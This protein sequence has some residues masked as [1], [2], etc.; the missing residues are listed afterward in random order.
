MSRC[1]HRG[2]TAWLEGA[3]EVVRTDT[4]QEE[5]DLPNDCVL[6]V[7]P[8]LVVLKLNM[9]AVLNSHLHL[10]GMHLSHVQHQPLDKHH[11]CSSGL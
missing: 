9:Q 3:A 6:Q 4:H 8:A 2:K 1:S 11:A 5:V 7:V 10:Q